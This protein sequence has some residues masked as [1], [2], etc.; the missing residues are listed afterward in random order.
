[1]KIKEL[2][3]K[4][5]EF[6][7]PYRVTNGSKFRLKDFDPAD[8]LHL[9]SEDKPRAKEG[10]QVGVDGLATLQEMLYAQ[11]KWAVLLIFQAM[12]AMDTFRAK[13]IDVMGQNNVIMKEQL[14]RSEQYIDRVRQQQA[15]AVRAQAQRSA[16]QP[17]ASAVSAGVWQ[18]ILSG[19]GFLPFHVAR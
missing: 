6:A 14:T 18:V 9:D 5:R 7:D 1:M 11:D 16:V 17:A 2:V 4:A 15:R 13:A 8:T 10:L 19:R 3:K 12:D